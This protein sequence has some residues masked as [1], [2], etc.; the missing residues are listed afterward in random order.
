MER[1]FLHD[2][3]SPRTR[4]NTAAI[5]AEAAEAGLDLLRRNMSPG[6][7][8]R[9][10]TSSLFSDLDLSLGLSGGVGGGGGGDDDDGGIGGGR[11]DARAN[12]GALTP[13]RETIDDD[14]SFLRL[15]TA[16]RAFSIRDGDDGDSDLDVDDEDD[17]FAIAAAR[18]SHAVLNASGA[19]RAHQQ[20]QPQRATT[21]GGMP[22]PTPRPLFGGAAATAGVGGGGRVGIGVGPGATASDVC[23]FVSSGSSFTEQHW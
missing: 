12:A 20:Q 5:A 3:P 11:D 18:L 8:S 23:T 9:L 22:I 6:A 7:R 1:E 14:A 2:I 17:E 4:A 16:S 13:E 19:G 10:L 21:S 15:A